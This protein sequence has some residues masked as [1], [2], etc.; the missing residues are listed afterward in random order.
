MNKVLLISEK[1]I[2]A[3]TIIEQNVDAKILSKV[4]LNAQ[5]T[6]LRSILGADLY[7]SVLKMVADKVTSG[8]T[9]EQPYATLIDTYIQPYLVN[10]TLVDFLVVNNYK[11]TNK[12]VLKMRDDVAESLNA[13]E[14][15]YAR[16]YYENYAVSYKHML[17]E[18]LKE[19]GLIQHKTD[20]DIT[21]PST[22]W[23]LE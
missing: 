12:G 8:T 6:K 19:S 22:G 7:D 13:Q 15:D 10:A 21:S 23:Y 5:E 2:K 11:I 14:L 17:I 4:I 1:Q 9:I 18:Y 20:T 3:Q 16:N